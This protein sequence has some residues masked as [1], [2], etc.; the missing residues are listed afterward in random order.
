MLNLV[1]HKSQ[2]HFFFFYAGTAPA[3]PTTV[4]KLLPQHGTEASI[5]WIKHEKNAKAGKADR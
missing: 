5:L 1:T 2:L 4:I 3:L